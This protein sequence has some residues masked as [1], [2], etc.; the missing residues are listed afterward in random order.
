MAASTAGR[1]D[2]K[3]LM[4]DSDQP[5]PHN[6]SGDETEGSRTWDDVVVQ[7]PVALS[8]LE[9]DGT[10][11]S[12]PQEACTLGGCT[13]KAA[14]GN[15]HG[16]AAAQ[17]AAEAIATP[18][19]ALRNSTAA[20][21]VQTARTLSCVDCSSNEPVQASQQLSY[22]APLVST[23]HN[24]SG[25]GNIGNT[26]AMPGPSSNTAPSL[27]C[28]MTQVSSRVQPQHCTTV[29]QSATV[30]HNNHIGT[31][32][33]AQSSAARH[34]D[35][36]GTAASTST[37]SI[38]PCVVHDTVNVPATAVLIAQ[39]KCAAPSGMEQPTRKARWAPKLPLNPVLR[40]LESA[41]RDIDDGW[42]ADQLS[43]PP[44]VAELVGRLLHITPHGLRPHHSHPNCMQQQPVASSCLWI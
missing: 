41:L 36:L 30:R 10:H 33:G 7:L 34:C 15:S 28:I 12:A 44:T 20:L 29:L 40:R 22:A 39:S 9:K 25:T 43:K 31:A 2:H 27:R 3:A 5:K 4:A 32:A 8:E 14:S 11:L 1:T 19:T 38:H 42:N 16:A 6:G 24:G 35:N 21:A 37:T 18:R 17:G 26:S 23:W 13:A